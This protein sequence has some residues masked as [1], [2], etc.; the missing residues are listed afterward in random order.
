MKKD[1]AVK[2]FESQVALA[3]ALG[4]RP[5]AVSKWG[6]VVPKGAAYQ[7]QVITGGLLR[8]DESLYAKVKK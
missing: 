6:D 7:L 8:V 1:I 3:Q 4:I 5:Q 2:H